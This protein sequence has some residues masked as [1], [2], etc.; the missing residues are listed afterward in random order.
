M[1]HAGEAAPT[2]LVADDRQEIREILAHLL[3]REGYRVVCAQD[4]LQAL[5]ILR[6]N[7]VDLALLDVRMPGYSGFE[8]C[9]E[10]KDRAQTRLM[11]VVLITS[12]GSSDDRVRGIECG[13][14]D[15]LSK[16]VRKEEL[17]A[18]VRSL[19]RVK[20]YTD[21]LE[22]VESVLCAL[23]RSIEAK[24]PYLDGHGD[25]VALFSFALADRIN[26]PTDL[27][28]TLGRAGVVH[29]IGKIVLPEA[30]LLKAG[31]LDAA[32]RKIVEMHPVI[33][34]RI[35][36][37]LRSLRNILP[38]IRHHHEHLDGSGYPDGL[39]GDAIPLPARILQIV[40]A[41][42]AL[43]SDRPYRRGLS[44]EAALEVLRE[45]TRRGW[46][47]PELVKEFCG[48]MESRRTEEGIHRLVGARQAAR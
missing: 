31:P 5:R 4:G 19:L 20:S 18:R 8:L 26:L 28:V 33:G 34:E 1:V 46:W 44:E 17:L 41:Y 10:V 12:P 38:V 23:A 32:E 29:D 36:E 30:I 9:R 25:R 48:L 22:H 2:I 13:A 7:P 3:R 16:P 42:D 21:G 39:C 47:D 24:D 6:E 11:P 45:E 15:L 43:T 37:P 40:D 14:D 35:C 27:R